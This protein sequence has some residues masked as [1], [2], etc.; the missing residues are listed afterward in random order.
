MLQSM[1]LQRIRHDLVTEQQH[2]LNHPTEL[3]PDLI[4]ATVLQGILLLII[5][6]T[7]QKIEVCRD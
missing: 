7:Y 5:T 4:L 3:S 2:V 1:W 6:L